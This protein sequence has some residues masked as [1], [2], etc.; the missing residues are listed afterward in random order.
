[1]ES[2]SPNERLIPVY[3]GDEVIYVTP[4]EYYL[5]FGKAV[6]KTLASALKEDTAIHDIYK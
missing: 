6:L 5:K 3:D 2:I 1:M 4:P